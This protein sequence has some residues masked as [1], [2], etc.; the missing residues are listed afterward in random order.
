[1]L[2]NEF[3]LILNMGYLLT[4]RTLN[5]RNLLELLELAFVLL[6]SKMNAYEIE[7]IGYNQ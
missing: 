1:M 7:T 2:I 3:N 4:S 6:R 5:S